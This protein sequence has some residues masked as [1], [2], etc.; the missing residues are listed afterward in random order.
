MARK[1]NT[2]RWVSIT[3][4]LYNYLGNTGFFIEYFAGNIS[5]HTMVRILLIYNFGGFIIQT[6]ADAYFKPDKLDNLPAEPKGIKS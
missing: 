3:R 4:K 5:D 1:T 2:P 6:I